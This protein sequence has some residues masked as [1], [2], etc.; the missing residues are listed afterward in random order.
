VQPPP[1][2]S[3]AKDSEH[4]NIFKGSVKKKVWK[5]VSRDWGGKL[6]HKAMLSERMKFNVAA[7]RLSI[8]VPSS[9]G[10]AAKILESLTGVNKR[11]KRINKLEDEKTED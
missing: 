2:V 10:V 7:H 1:E 9:S 6:R 4:P 11:H 5:E 8:R 3:A